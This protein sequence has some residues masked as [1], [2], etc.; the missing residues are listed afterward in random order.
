MFF[1]LIR[2]V[3][4]LS[5]SLIIIL[6]VKSKKIVR[7]NLVCILSIV[8]CLGLVS[9]SAI[10]PLENVFIN[11]KSPKQVF[12]Y[13]RLGKVNDILYGKDSC[14]VICSNLN[15]TYGHYIIPKNEKGYKVPNYFTEKKVLKKFDQNGSFNVYH[16][17]GTQDYY[18]SGTII[19]S[20]TN[21]NVV[22]N[23]NRQVK[24]VSINMGSTE[25]K[26][27][28]LYSYVENLKDEYYFF[29]NG[30]KVKIFE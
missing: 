18:V 11:F 30:T 28:F 7:K 17:S 25:I 9:V 8:I 13:T 20:S 16:V 21:Q 4:W 14:L 19:S 12:S 15:G 10:F 26:T 23:Y 2:I 6:K 27:V 22:D 29:I 1:D 5:I 24:T 3:L